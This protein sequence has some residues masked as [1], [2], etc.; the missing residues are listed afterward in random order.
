MAKKK[1]KKID[2]CIVSNIVLKKYCKELVYFRHHGSWAGQKQF[3]M[4]DWVFEVS[5]L[6]KNDPWTALGVAK[7]LIAIEVMTRFCRE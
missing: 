5:G 3:V 6:G 4:P 1:V 2:L 7:D